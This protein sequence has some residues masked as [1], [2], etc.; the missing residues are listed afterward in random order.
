VTVVAMDFG[1]GSWASLAVGAAHGYDSASGQACPLSA[2][3]VVG[4]FLAMIE[5]SVL[6]S[7]VS[8][9]M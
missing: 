4:Y 2:A 7:K 8:V 5:S 9:S 3:V 6:A 1:A